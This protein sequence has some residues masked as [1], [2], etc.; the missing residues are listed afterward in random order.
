MADG[1][2]V[3]TGENNIKGVQLM[4]IQRGLELQVKTGLGFS[5]NR[6]LHGAQAVLQAAG[7]KPKRTASAVLKQFAAYRAKWQAKNLP[8]IPL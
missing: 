4:T 5:G 6:V 3:I 2:I 8:H 1:T 7:I